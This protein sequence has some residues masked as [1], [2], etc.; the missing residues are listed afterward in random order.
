ME[1]SRILVAAPNEAGRNFIRLLLCKKLPVAAVTNNGREE[2]A[3]RKLGVNDI[4]H[5]NTSCIK[6]SAV[7]DFPIGRAYI[8]ESSLPLTCQYL[9]WIRP[10]TSQ[11]IIV[12]AQAWHSEIVYK[13]L[14]ASYVVRTQTGEVGFLL[15]RPIE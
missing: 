11:A 3:L 14:G 8:F 1:P 7:P 12:V 4:F 9:Q 15:S 13:K 10:W 5:V 6:G 2:K